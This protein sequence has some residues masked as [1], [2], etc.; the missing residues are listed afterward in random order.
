MPPNNTR[1]RMFLTDTG[2]ATELKQNFPKAAFLSRL[3][4][5]LIKGLPN[6][7]CLL[8]CSKRKDIIN[9]IM[10][11]QICGSITEA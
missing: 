8:M 10:P 7:G 6:H 11:S 5:D 4:N 1:H 2:V 9:N 3:W